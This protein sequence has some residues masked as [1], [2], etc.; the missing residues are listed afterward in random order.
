MPIKSMFTL[1]KKLIPKKIDNQPFTITPLKNEIKMYVNK[2]I[3][4]N[5]P[6]EPIYIKSL[7]GQLL[8]P[9]IC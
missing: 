2:I 3:E 5:R 4:D 6:I 1:P 8:K 7:S 9:I